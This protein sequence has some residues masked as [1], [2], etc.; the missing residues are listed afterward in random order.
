M[1][2]RTKFDRQGNSTSIFNQFGYVKN[3]Y[4]DAKLAQWKDNNVP[5]EERWVEIFRHMNRED[6]P[7]KEFAY[8]IEFALCFPGTSASVERIFA[9]AK[10][11]WTEEKANLHVETL[12]AILFVKNNLQYDCIKFHQFLLTQPELLKRISSQE[13]YDFKQTKVQKSPKAMSIYEE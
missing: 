12:N 2:E 13:K 3:Y 6:V 9:K 5:K 7:F 8:I 1:A 4:T 11:I 10:K